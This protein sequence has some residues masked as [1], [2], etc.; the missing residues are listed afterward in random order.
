MIS[1][2]QQAVVEVVRRRDRHVV[3][4]ATAGSGKTTTLV[5]IAEAIGHA[6]HVCFLAFNRSAARE[7]A[8]RLPTGTIATTLHALGYEV[9]KREVGRVSI[10]PS[11]PHKLALNIIREQLGWA[12]EL[13]D[14]GAAYVAGLATIART[15]CIPPERA[16]ELREQY[17]VTPPVSGADL[18]ALHDVF[19]AVLTQG[20]AQAERGIVDYPDLLYQPT[21]LALR[22]PRFD[23]V[24]VDEAQDLSPASFALVRSLIYPNTTAVFVGDPHQAIYGFAGAQSEMMHRLV[25]ELGAENLPLSV[26]F[27][28]P[29]RHVLL[30]RGF[31]PN[32][33]ARRGAQIGEVRT[34]TPAQL[35]RGV[36]PGALVL[37]R[38][39]QEL[40]NPLFALIR[41]AVPVQVLGMPLRTWAG[42]VVRRLAQYKTGT[43]RQRIERFAE[44]ERRALERDHIMSVHLGTKLAEHREDVRLAWAL[45]HGARYRY[46][47]VA[48]EQLE[49]L[50]T[51]TFTRKKHT[52]V[53][54][55]IH[56]AKGRE[57]DHV[58]VLNPEWFHVSKEEEA[59]LLF[60][61]V[62]RAKQSIT[63]VSAQPRRIVAALPQSLTK[64]DH[65]WR[66]TLQLA[67]TFA[68]S[69]RGTWWSR[70]QGVSSPYERSR[71]VQSTGRE[72]RRRRS[73]TE[74]DD[75]HRRVD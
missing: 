63:F 13:A 29:Q 74:R 10:L 32:M 47:N 22:M 1:A 30:A 43:V 27:R 68:R 31:S 48:L 2:E 4:E 5:H 21:Q 38:R 59:N 25:A 15:E 67:E 49:Q 58:Y 9:L 65:V 70:L 64:G 33:S 8:R 57:A 45:A 7:L 42:N 26:S 12:G 75:H 18:A 66:G 73:R 3:V 52:V 69:Q 11:K 14:L 53:L 37:A 44:E 60:V 24:C 55:T 20:R 46:G 36:E 34:C 72:T 19:P 39:N 71:R 17:G 23:V 56:K 6:A 61:A 50:V 16:L 62:T 28:C 40:I 54:S 51:E 41:R 35:P